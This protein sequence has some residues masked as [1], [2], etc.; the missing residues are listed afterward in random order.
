MIRVSFIL[1]IVVFLLY[2]YKECRKFIIYGGGG[3]I[4]TRPLSSYIFLPGGDQLKLYK[5]YKTHDFSSYSVLMGTSAG[6]SLMGEIMPY[7]DTYYKGLGLIKGL[8]IDQHFSQRKRL[9]RLL[10]ILR[11]N[12]SFIGIGIDEETG[13]IY[14]KGKITVFGRYN[15][16]VC[17]KKRL[18]ILFP[19]DTYVIP[20]L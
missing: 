4:P 11:E 7:K 19:G 8:I 12:P 5:I 20:C 1:F 14:E 6:S 10:N 9:F 13:I 16:H 3:V 18:T 15:V 2:P 17:Y